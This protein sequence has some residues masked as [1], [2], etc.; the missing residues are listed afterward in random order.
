M[1]I[2]IAAFGIYSSSIVKAD[3]STHIHTDACYAGHRH[4]E[5]GCIGKT[6]LV[7][8]S[9]NYIPR[10]F[11]GTNGALYDGNFINIGYHWDTSYGDANTVTAD[12]ITIKFIEDKWNYGTSMRE[13]SYITV[14]AYAYVYDLA[15]NNYKYTAVLNKS[16]RTFEA[17]LMT[18]TEEYNKIKN[19][20]SNMDSLIDSGKYSEY[21]NLLSSIGIYCYSSQSAVMY[22]RYPSVGKI[23]WSCGI[24]QDE[25]PICGSVAK[26]I[27]AQSPSQTIY[28]GSSF[29]TNV[30]VTYLNESTGIVGSM[31]TGFNPSIL[32]SQII[33]LSYNGLINTAKATGTI[34]CNTTV[35]VIDYVISIIPTVGNQTVY[36][37]G[38]IDATATISK[39]SGESQAV[40]CE[41]SG[42]S[43]TSVGNQTVTL[44]Y[45]GLTTN[46]GTYPS[47]TVN[48][49]VLPG[50]TKI[51]PIM[52][53]QIIYK[54]TAPN[55]TATA[56]Y[57]DN[58]TKAVTPTNNFN[59]SL[60]G[61]QTVT[62]TY[63]DQGI[64]KTTTSTVTVLP[65]LTGL[66][67]SANK[68]SVL[69][70]TD[71]T[72][73]VR[74]SYEDSSSK[75]VSAAVVKGYNKNKLGSQTIEF[76]YS[77]N[78]NTK[79]A[80]IS[81][82]VLD[83][84]TSID[85]ELVTNSLYQSQTITVKK[86]TASLATGATANIT[87]TV[88]SYDNM[89]IGTKNITFSYTMNGVTVTS[90]KSIE[91]RP[92]LYGLDIN[93]DSFTIYKGQSLPIVVKAK[94]NIGGVV[95]LNA[96]AY[97]I[98][99]FDNNVYNRNGR[100]YTLSYT[101]KGVTLTRQI[102]IV[103]KPNIK[104]M[105]LTVPPQGTEGSQ[106]PFTMVI[107]YEDGVK[108]TLTEADIGS[109]IGLSITD[110]DKN[111]VGYQNTKL[112]YS[113]GDK[114]LTKTATVRIR[115][116]IKVS[117]PLGVMMSIDSNT[118]QV[119]ASGVTI[120]NQSKE[121]VL[122]SVINVVKAQNNEVKDV[123]PDKY[124]DW[125]KLGRKDSNNIAIGLNYA[126]DNWLAKNLAAPLYFV[127]LSGTGKRDI[128][129]IE[130]GT[131]SLLDFKIK[132][133]NAFKNSQSFQYVINWMIKL[134]ED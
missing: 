22:N 130:K 94:F 10:S 5:S 8:S 87:P 44:T 83:Y 19:V 43:P 60:I 103:V 127:E 125:S 88:S 42:F 129:V 15:S 58:T 53:N 91:I 27:T 66:T 77:E 124:T 52:K 21:W 17:D 121:S 12:G 69:Y 80:A 126:S 39:A 84:P 109:D 41:V 25:V 105:T 14:T 128:G 134:A 35:N 51:E 13:F 56:Y 40:T 18:T 28:Y 79:N 26:A 57:M 131:K 30:I 73:T 68:T 132:H 49:T 98:T 3:V 92:D 81:V 7:P 4:G 122:I 23:F 104:D 37:N 47:C 74:A 108:K 2:A 95:T 99:G 16:V 102:F 118:G 101:D 33:T 100:Y 9:G 61:T 65:N 116:L 31:V 46:T 32:G 90:N 50:L 34:T 1:I 133:G 110:Y 96:S 64:T 38:S 20:Y 45:K 107:N 59:P 78:G 36:Y 63:T 113:E 76:S 24:E 120:D 71:I 29:D 106:V 117:I 111:Y 85:V 119:Y 70:G 123:S 112:R 115:A 62:L 55:L 75:I 86:A 67:V 97:T 54:G 72:F 114:F 93:S 89:T 11:G 48:V 82:E 6:I